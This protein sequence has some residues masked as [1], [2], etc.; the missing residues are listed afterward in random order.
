MTS[1]KFSPPVSTIFANLYFSIEFL[2]GIFDK[3]EKIL[4]F[5]FPMYLSYDLSMSQKYSIFHWSSDCKFAK[6]YV[7]R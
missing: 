6:R 4:I 7:F 2:G 5:P 3:S 1:D